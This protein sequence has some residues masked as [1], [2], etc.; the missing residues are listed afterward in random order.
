MT[1]IEE[2]VIKKVTQFRVEKGLSQR[3]FADN[4][5]LSQG[6]IR[7]IENPKKR[8]KYNLN[9]INSIVKIFACKFSDFVP[10]DGI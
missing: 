8:A 5:N 7:D 4:L 6:F 2:Y 3:E 1:P 10:E 9:H